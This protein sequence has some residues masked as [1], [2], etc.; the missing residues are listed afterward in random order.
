MRTGVPMKIIIFLLSLIMVSYCY[1]YS[2]PYSYTNAAGVEIYVDGDDVDPDDVDASI[3]ADARVCNAGETLVA[4]CHLP[5]KIKRTAAFCANDNHEIRYFFKKADNIELEV[6]FDAKNKLKRWLDSGTYSTY[7]GFNRG[8][9]SYVLIVPEERCGV[10]AILDIKKNGEI[11]SS[12]DCSS[13][14]FGEKDIK[15]NSIEDVPDS[16]VRDNHFKFP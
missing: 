1:S 12:K 8:A 2:C 10:V 6:R 13:N 9:Y 4:S 11:I 5:G 14:S 15:S 16:L 3:E 7:F